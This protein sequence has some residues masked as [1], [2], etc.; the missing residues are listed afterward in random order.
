MLLYIIYNIIYSIYIYVGVC[1][2][3]SEL[4]AVIQNAIGGSIVAARDSCC[5]CTCHA[6][7]WAH[8]AVP[9]KSRAP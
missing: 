2:S 9:R 5:L 4:P 7:T 3:S 6:H 8:A 1:F